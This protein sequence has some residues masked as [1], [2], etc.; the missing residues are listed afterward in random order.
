MRFM[1]AQHLEAL[2]QVC[3]INYLHNDGCESMF[4]QD[5]DASIPNVEKDVSILFKFQ[6]ENSYIELCIR[7]E[8]EHSP[9]G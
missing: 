4:L 6:E 7:E 8:Q 9:Q 1:I 2:L 3:T 5:I